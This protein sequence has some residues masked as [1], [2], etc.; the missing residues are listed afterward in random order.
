MRYLEKGT[1]IGHTYR[2]VGKLGSGGG[3]TVYLAMHERTCHL[4]AVK[5][6][7][8]ANPSVSKN[9]ILCLKHLSHPGL[10]KL[11]DVLEGEAGWFLVMEYIPGHTLEE[12]R[13]TAGAS[14]EKQVFGWME[15]LCS[16]LTYLHERTPA[17]IYGD[18][19]PSNI[20]CREDGRLVL[21]DFGAARMDDGGWPLIA[22]TAGYAAPEQ[23]QEDG[24]IDTRTD[25]YA[26][27]ITMTQML[28]GKNEVFGIKPKGRLK[29]LLAQCLRVEKEARY[30]SCRE[31][32][33][34]L[35][36]V[37]KRRS[38]LIL[39][40]I[41]ILLGILG[42][43]TVISDFTARS[44][45]ETRYQN[46][47]NSSN[48]Q[49]IKSAIILSPGREEAYQKLL[50]QILE[51]YQMDLQ[52]E[53]VFRSI[54][55]KYEGELEIHA[56]NYSWLC[57][58]AGMAYWYHFE[59]SS[60]KKQAALWFEKIRAGDLEEKYEVQV[61]AFCTLNEI[62]ELLE[63]KNMTG[64]RPVSYGK[65]WKVCMELIEGE[66][67]KKD[68]AVTSLQIWNEVAGIQYTYMSDFKRSG[69]SYEEMKEMIG[70]L[71]DGNAGIEGEDG[72]SVVPE[73]KEGL[74]DKIVLA[75]DAIGMLYG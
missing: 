16:V 46:Y 30:A 7:S 29:G 53:E 59:G 37:K 55:E 22:G 23:L 75:E 42:L 3:G 2:I 71:R 6:I 74:E 11:L 58:Q 49:E 44:R 1:I 64:D 34:D 56:A 43:K 68:N 14:G 72:N 45:Q 54:L 57:Y 62:Y 73:Y 26:L 5:E 13:A 10:P 52:E 12:I 31:L 28:S 69:V 48:I 19:K 9:E 24:E 20:I 50:K 18:L 65:L 4:W 67:V 15:Q 36:R 35:K 41:A 27:G 21:I 51:D 47:L 38:L 39:S 25:I 33:K 66:A 61:R 40:T 17:I 70:I 63:Q 32:E 8:K 60:R